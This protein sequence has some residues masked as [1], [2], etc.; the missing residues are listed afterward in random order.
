MFSYVIL[1]STQQTI[2]SE[3]YGE[4]S[5]QAEDMIAREGWIFVVIAL[6]LGLI[7]SGLLLLIP[8]IPVMLE[9]IL[10]PLLLP[11]FGFMVACFFRDP[12]RVLPEDADS[13]I[14]SPADGKI[15]EIVQEEES[16]FVGGSAWRI[17]IFLSILNVHVNRIPI[18]GIVR[19]LTYKSGE[20]RL[21]WDPKSSTLNEQSQIGIE[22]SN[23]K[24]VLF[25][26]IAG[27]LARRVVFHVSEGD[28]VK[29]G[30]RFGLIRF[31]SRMDVLF[32]A[33]L[34][35]KVKVNERVSAGVSVLGAI[36]PELKGTDEPNQSDS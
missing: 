32:P 1:V 4:V 5:L 2:V 36:H 9:L 18:S 14:L 28:Q 8:G 16:L 15:L 19:Y 21:A 31:G 22:H 23:G 26:Q 11:G 33:D 12:E 25:K 7:L 35:V 6:F 24:R 3:E 20:F 34:P 13:L 10:V 27:T 29:A 30:R 17:S